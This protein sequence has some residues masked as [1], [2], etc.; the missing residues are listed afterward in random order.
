MTEGATPQWTIEDLKRHLQ[1]TVD[2]ELFTIPFYLTALYSIQD[3]TSDAYKLIQSVVIEEMLHLELACNLNRVFGQ[4]P[5]AKPLAYDYDKGAIPHINEG[6]DHIDPKLKAQ[7]TPHVIKL[8]S[9]SEN[10]IN[11]MALVE[12]PEDRTGRQPDMNPSSTE[13]GSIGLL[14]DAVHFGVNQL[15]ETYVN[16]DISLVQLDGQFLSDFEGRPLQ[17]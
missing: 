11:V 1:Y 5:L 3:S 17:I 12:L 14:Y 16:T 2:L 10:T 15:Y 4:I 9:C 8:G 6:M 7:L 13:Y